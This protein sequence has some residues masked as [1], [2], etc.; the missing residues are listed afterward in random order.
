MR[1]NNWLLVGV[2]GVGTMTAA[3][4]AQFTFQTVLDDQQTVFA[5]GVPAPQ[6]WP[7]TM[8]VGSGG[9]V[10][11]VLEPDDG[12]NYLVY[13]SPTQGMKVVATRNEDEGTWSTGTA[14]G[15]TFSSFSN[16]AI[17]DGNRL[18]FAAGIEGTDQG[19]YQYDNA[20]NQNVRILRSGSS[21]KDAGLDASND[22]PYMVSLDY[23]INN[24]GQVGISAYTYV[25]PTYAP[26]YAVRGTA[27]GIQVVA[28][29]PGD[30][31]DT[32]NTPTPAQPFA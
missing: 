13:G 3:A 8:V 25:G 28:Q 6:Y 32:F 26:E 19:I 14:S 27:S 31:A 5:G 12:S 22:N 18:T 30:Y 17:S 2:A 11:A 15:M 9:T 1:A 23:K 29:A 24:S 10:A 7:Y 20:A 21:A 16:L 4:Q